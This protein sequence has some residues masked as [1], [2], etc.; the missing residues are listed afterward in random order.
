[1]E[2]LDDFETVLM[3]WN[4]MPVND[5]NID[6]AINSFKNFIGGRTNS[7]RRK[8]Y[9]Q[10][11]YIYVKDIF[12]TKIN[13][14]PRFTN[15]MGYSELTVVMG[16]TLN[17]SWSNDFIRRC[18][19]KYPSNVWQYHDEITGG[20]GIIQIEFYDHFPGLLHLRCAWVPEEIAHQGIATRMMQSIQNIAKT[21]QTICEEDRYHGKRIYGNNCT[22]FLVPNPFYVSD[23]TLNQ[24]ENTIDWSHPD[25]PSINMIDETVNELPDDKL[26]VSWQELR[27]FYKR[28][29]FVEVPEMDTERV[30]DERLCKIIDRRIMANRSYVIGRHPMLWP[31]ENVKYYI[32]EK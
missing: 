31:M 9:V 1:M 21:T 13:S 22:L 32:S 28:I 29:G 24:D 30:Y 26:R 16:K 18:E 4:P 14:S 7:S 20:G 8:K 12:K 2:I 25:S 15:L 23:W 10:Q 17:D 19:R 11:D 5:P 3:L 27:D 6:T